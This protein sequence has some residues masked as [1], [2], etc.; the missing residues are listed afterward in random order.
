MDNKQLERPFLYS[1][2]FFCWGI[3]IAFT[4]VRKTCREI[5]WSKIE[6]VKK[7]KQA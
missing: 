3:S 5:K 1:N 2:I 7:E 4:Y 6:L